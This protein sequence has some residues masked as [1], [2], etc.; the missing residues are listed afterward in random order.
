MANT[1]AAP[2]VKIGI[3]GCGNIFG[4]YVKGCRVFNILEIAACA[5]LNMPLAEAKAAEFNIPKAVTVSELLADPEIQIVINLT[6]PKVHAEVSRSI[7][8]AGK[9][10]YSEKPLATTRADGRAILDAAKAA[11]VRVGCAPDTFLGGGLQTCR[12]LIEDGWIGKPVS[13]TGFM[14]GHGPES[15]HPNPGFFYQHG[16]GPLFDMGPYY[17]TA[18]IS[19]LGPAHRVT[20]ST[21]MAYTERIATSKEQFGARLPV[22]VATHISGV[23]DF[24]N[25]AIATLI[26]S[27]DVWKHNL[28][29]LEIHGTEGSLSVPDPNTFGGVVKLHRAGSNQW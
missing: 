29:N 21:G 6:I 18:L 9:H 11:N 7:I 20:A 10:P 16:G 12:K 2:K 4:A 28:P 17:L 23:I 1:E 14:M 3:I 15:W 13:A 19:L 22:E 24:D 25:G 5:D 26:T 27:F 8:A